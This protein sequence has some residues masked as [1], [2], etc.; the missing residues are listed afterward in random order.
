VKNQGN[1]LMTFRAFSIGFS[2]AVLALACGSDSNNDS[3]TKGSGTSPGATTDVP[4]PATDIR[5][6]ET[7]ADNPLLAGCAPVPSAA[8]STPVAAAPA[9]VTDSDPANLAKAAAENVL[10]ANCGQCHGPALTEQ[11]AQA[12]MNYI[13]DIDKLVST[14]KII[15]L[16]SAG[17]RIIQRM[18]RGEMPPPSSGLPAVTEADI[19]TVAQYIDNPR[20][21]PGV[22][23]ADCS[24]K[25]QL[26]DFDTLYQQVNRDLIT[27]DSQDTPFFRY[28]SLSNRFTAGVCADNLD[29]DRQALAK[30]MNMLSVDATPGDVVPVDT[31][32]TVFRIDLRDFQWNRAISVEGQAFTDVWE[33]IAANNPYAVELIGDDAD[34]AKQDTQTQFPVMFSDQMMDVATIGN[35]Y[36]AII[37]V[38][39]NQPLGDFIL[40]NLGIDVAQDLLDRDEIRAGTTKSRVSRQDRLVER[41]DIQ[42]RGGAFWQSFDFEANDANQ[43]IFQDPFGFAA[44]GSE[45][46]FTLPNGMLGFI[47]ADANDNIVEDSDIL[48]DTNQNNFRAVTS[49]SCSN[50]HAS[51]FIPVVDEVKDVALDSARDIGLNRDEVEQLQEIYVSPQEFAKQVQE[52]SSAFYQRALQEVDLPIQGADPVSSTWLRF[53]AD[54]QLKDAAGD[55][56]L[57]PDDL[58]N[59]LDL[60]NP[61]ASVLRTGTLDRDDFTNIYIDSLCVLSTPL[62]NQPD[63]AVCDAA[64]AALGI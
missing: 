30:M 56:G 34:Q 46:I 37:D 2:A 31:D 59:N 48:L 57:T 6:T 26:T 38:D 5:P 4:A 63:P 23:V 41:H 58:L 36:Y 28:I 39:I 54:V 16:N 44:G 22:P 50:C 25:N 17:S 52:D 32:Q 12:G 18:T 10:A 1:K 35:L 40:N 20:F 24:S 42:V 14:G 64:A 61:V 45:A 51:G 9:P 21:W 53:D 43:S 60:L 49:I 11:Q 55:L 29:K 62:E 13:N 8:G 33:A 27:A 19:N 7:C 47:I 3:D 15:P